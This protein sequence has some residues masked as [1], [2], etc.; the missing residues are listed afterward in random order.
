MRTKLALA[1]I[2]AA[3][4]TSVARAADPA[5]MPAITD[6]KALRLSDADLQ[7]WRDLK[8]GM[9]IHWGLYAIPAQGEWYMND[10]KVPADEYRKLADQFNPQHYDPAA[11]AKIAKDAGMKYMVLTARHHDGFA[12]WDSPSSYMQFDA[13]H[14]A[15]KRDLVAPF[16]KAARDAGMKVGLYYSPMDWRFPGYFDPKGQPENAALMKKQAWGQIEELTKNYGQIDILWYDGGWLA[17]KGSDADAAPFW[18]SD[19]LAQMVR[20]YQPKA[21]ISPR[22]GWVGDFTVDE[23][24]SAVTGPIKPGA[25]EKALNLNETSWGF[26][27]K[28]NLMSRDRALSMLVNTVVRGGNMLLNVGPDKDGMIPEAHAARL[29][30]IGE[31]MATYGESIYG[32]RAGPLQPLENRGQGTVY[33]TTYRDKTI[34]LHVLNWRRLPAGAARQRGA[35]AGTAGTAEPEEM[36]LSALKQKIISAT[37]LNAPAAKVTVS[38]TDAGVMVAL[39]RENHDPFDTIIALQCDAAITP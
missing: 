10:K 12:L 17:M 34:Y 38:Q 26:N 24:G 7:P 37:C 23:G 16:V 20:W 28:Q 1:L 27:T 25:W 30:E 29:K 18:E 15:A 8:F 19:K 13:V 22:S 31:W 11:W 2:V 9:F 21:I 32:T 14:S 33:G 39:P 35:P 4:G 6:P 36:A 5:T 3:A